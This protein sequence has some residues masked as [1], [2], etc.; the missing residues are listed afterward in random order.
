[1]I[2]QFISSDLSAGRDQYRHITF[3]NAPSLPFFPFSLSRNPVLMQCMHRL[4]ETSALFLLLMSWLHLVVQLVLHTMGALLGLEWKA[5]GEAPVTLSGFPVPGLDASLQS[6][7]VDWELVDLSWW[8]Y[9]STLHLQ[10][11]WLLVPILTH[12]VLARKGLTASQTVHHG[13][14][15]VPKRC[16]RS[17]YR[18]WSKTGWVSGIHLPLSTLLSSPSYKLY[19]IASILLYCIFCIKVTKEKFMLLKIAWN[20]FHFPSF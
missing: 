14:H 8:W 11:V 17:H 2:S 7:S 18:E 20:L 10:E 5:G 19:N 9:H 15:G 13:A 1:M 4:P 16:F 12:M 6:C 3:H